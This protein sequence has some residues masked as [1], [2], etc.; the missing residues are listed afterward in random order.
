LGTVKLKLVDGR[1]AAKPLGEIDIEVEAYWASTTPVVLS[2]EGVY[3]LG[4]VTVE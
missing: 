1:V 2:D 3:L 4:A